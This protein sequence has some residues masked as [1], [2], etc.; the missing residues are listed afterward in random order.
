V[1]RF[2][3]SRG[4]VIAEF[5]ADERGEFRSNRLDDL[6]NEPRIDGFELFRIEGNTGGAGFI[7]YF[8]PVGRHTAFVHDT[9]GRPVANGALKC[10][11]V[12]LGKS[13]IQSD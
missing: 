13:I 6:R 7:Y 5:T 11:R 12:S 1:V 4:R 3:D 8:S 2:R 10:R 9:S